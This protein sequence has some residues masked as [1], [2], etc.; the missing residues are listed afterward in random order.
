MGNILARGPWN[1]HT[2]LHGYILTDLILNRLLKLFRSI[3]ADGL[4]LNATIIVIFCITL[5]FSNVNT[6][7]LRNVTTF[8]RWLIMTNFLIVNLPAHFLG[9]GT[10]NSLISYRA[11]LLGYILTIFLGHLTAHLFLNLPVLL[12]R[13]S[14]AHIGCFSSTFP[15]IGCSALP[16][17]GRLTRGFVDGRTFFLINIRTFSFINSGANSVFNCFT[18]RRILGGTFTIAAC[19]TLT[20]LLNTTNFFGDVRTFAF[21]NSMTLIII[22]HLNVPI[23]NC[24]WNSFLNSRTFSSGSTTANFIILGTTFSLVL[25]GC[26]W[27]LLVST[28]LI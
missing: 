14:L 24:M 23:I 9:C 1:I 6:V 11:L 12:L 7:L 20:I 15:F 10:T 13:N 4:V 2:I 19:V 28:L 16:I 26:N 8:L 3:I 18:H 21:I 5:L 27:F 25:C 17:T 22:H